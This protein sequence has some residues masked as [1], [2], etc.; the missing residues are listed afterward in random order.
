MRHRPIVAGVSPAKLMMFLVY[1][2]CHY[3]SSASIINCDNRQ[4]GCP[5]I[6][7]GKR[8]SFIKLNETAVTQN[9]RNEY[10]GSSFFFS[11]CHPSVTLGESHDEDEVD[12]DES[13]EV[14]H[15][16]SVNHH[17]ERPDRF[18]APAEE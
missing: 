16:H 12:G 13:E 10:E 2:T 9:Q 15:D 3:V 1:Y 14:A 8:A 18:E 17:D 5:F 7:S 6:V 11:K 4:Q